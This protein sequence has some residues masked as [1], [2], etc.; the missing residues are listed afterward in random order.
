[1]SGQQMPGADCEDAKPFRRR[2][3]YGNEKYHTAGIAQ[4]FPIRSYGWAS[5]W[6]GQPEHVSHYA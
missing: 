3:R 6:D 1:M 5:I 2:L 4:G